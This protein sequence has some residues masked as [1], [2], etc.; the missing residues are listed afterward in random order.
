M[1]TKVCMLL[2]VLIVSGAMSAFGSTQ[3]ST[4]YAHVVGLAN[5][6]DYLWVGSDKGLTR[7]L[8]NNPQRV[9]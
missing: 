1:K 2:M 9:D 4:P 3:G 7:F 5:D 8:W 6:G